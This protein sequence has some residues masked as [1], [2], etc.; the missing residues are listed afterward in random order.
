[1]DGNEHNS[2]SSVK[3]LQTIGRLPGI[4]KLTSLVYCLLD[5]QTPF[6]VRASGLFAFI[7]LVFPID[8]IPDFL[9]IIFGLGLADDAAVLYMAYKAAESSIRPEHTA[10]ALSFFHLQD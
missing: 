4:L 1:M 5:D 2:T 3:L 9:A 8:L 10:K 7:Y 6:M